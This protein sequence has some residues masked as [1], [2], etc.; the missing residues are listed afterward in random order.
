MSYLL[1]QSPDDEHFET[2]AYGYYYFGRLN[3]SRIVQM[4][5]LILCVIL[6]F[7]LCSIW[8]SHAVYKRTV[9]LIKYTRIFGAIILL[10]SMFDTII[11]VIRNTGIS[12]QCN[13]GIYFI[14][15]SPYI[16]K[17]YEL[18]VLSDDNIAKYIM[19]SVDTPV[20]ILKK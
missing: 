11:P 15:H 8:K 13:R 6:I 7:K 20:L 17:N 1:L 3:I 16:S 19:V 4:I 12:K 18:T 14:C 5:Y 10:G 9:W 2:C